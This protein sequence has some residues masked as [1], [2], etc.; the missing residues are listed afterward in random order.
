L[1]LPAPALFIFLFSKNET[2]NQLKF[3]GKLLCAATVFLITSCGNSEDKTA[4][5]TTATDTTTMAPADEA[6]VNTV[7]TTPE[8]TMVVRHKV[9]D[10]DKWLAS[11]EAHDSMKLANGLHNYV[12]GRSMDDPNMLLVATKADDL[13]KAKAFGKSADLRAAMKTTGVLGMPVIQYVRNVYQDTAQISTD[14]RVMSM[15]TVKDWDAWKT[16]FESHKD[17]RMAAGLVDRVYGYDPDDNKKVTLVLAVTDSAKAN[18]FWNSAELKEKMAESG[19]VGK[20]ERFVF[21]IS[22][23]Y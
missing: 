14:I 5:E 6:P 19:V 22:K 8:I 15:L 4:T 13:D 17:I 1:Q 16:S 3:Y 23:R 7:V 20:P 9:T 21:R 18:A 2:M 10:Y 12:V 11:F